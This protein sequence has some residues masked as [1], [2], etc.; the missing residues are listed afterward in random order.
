VSVYGGW[1]TATIADE[2]TDSGETDLGHDYD[3]LDIIIPTID[4]ASLTLKVANVA[5]GTYQT[6][7]D[8]IKTAATT[9]GYS[10]TFKL[11][12][13]QHI[14]VISSPKQSTSAVSFKVRG[15]RF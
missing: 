5:G 9:G 13:W 4:S 2:G 8:G 1:K 10:D 7:G 14:K 12:G 6:L 3:F 11:G 15:W